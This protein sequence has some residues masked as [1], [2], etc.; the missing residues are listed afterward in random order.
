MLLPLRGRCKG[1]EGDGVQADHHLHLEDGAG[2]LA[3]GGGLDVRWRLRGRIVG[4]AKQTTEG[5]APDRP[6]GPVEEKPVT[7]KVIRA[8]VHL[9]CLEVARLVDEEAESPGRHNL[10]VE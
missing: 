5:Q 2:H 4:C 9:A 8:A 6:E 3:Q 1:R 7:E 10:L